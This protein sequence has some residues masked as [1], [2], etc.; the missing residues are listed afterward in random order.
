MRPRRK[1]LRRLIIWNAR[2]VGG[3]IALV[4]RVRMIFSC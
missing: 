2:W 4:A 3:I 1:L